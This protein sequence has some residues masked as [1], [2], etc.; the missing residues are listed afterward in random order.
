M[1]PFPALRSHVDSINLDTLDST[2]LAHVPYIV[3]IIK[4]LQK[5]ASKH[6]GNA[7]ASGWEGYP[8][9][10]K[11]EE[12]SE[13]RALIRQLATVKPDEENF[14]EATNSVMPQ[15][16]RYEIPTEIKVI[17][18]DPAAS[19][20]SNAAAVESQSNMQQV[21]LFLISKL[22]IVLV[23]FACLFEG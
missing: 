16:V 4:A 8:S 9:S 2:D 5:F 13:L 1:C 12:K 22:R 14:E 3:L 11:W 10:L 23:F 18:E 19:V 20:D 15:C 7:D 21:S 6:S 17:L